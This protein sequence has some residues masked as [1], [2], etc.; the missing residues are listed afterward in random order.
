[1]IIITGATGKLGQAIAE[2]LLDKLPADQ[3]GVSVRDP[4]KARPLSER[5]V[6]V[7][8]GDYGDAL[9]LRHA[10]GGASQV[11]IVSSDSTG[12]DAIRHHRNAIDAAKAVGVQRILY[13]SHMGSNPASPFSPMR[14]HAA[15]ETLLEKSGIPFTSL[16][17]GFYTSSA[18]QL[19][20]RALETGKLIAPED[21]VVSWT[22]HADLVAA[23]VI[24]L[25]REE[26]LTGITPPLTGQQALNFADVAAIVSELTGQ[27]I[28]RITVPDNEWRAGL[29]SRGVPESRGDLLVGIFAASRKGEFAAVNPTLEHLL[30]RPPLSFRDV[31]GARLAKGEKTFF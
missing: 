27:T 7:R 28:T 15:T 19:M 11:L 10:F 1:M 6:R 14:G 31:L 2:Q 18:L 3:I 22:S 17:N 30:G 20:G 29:I 16:R 8:Q 13:T 25:T 24:A 26:S 21:G 4:E 5:D 12:E 23:A 9:S